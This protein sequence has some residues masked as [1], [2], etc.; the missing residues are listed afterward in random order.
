MSSRKFE[1]QDKSAVDSK[2]G[3]N[4]AV[5]CKF[6]APFCITRSDIIIPIN[7]YREIVNQNLY[8]LNQHY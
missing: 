2:F 1:L 4:V 8:I 7:G 6:N 3:I 5:N